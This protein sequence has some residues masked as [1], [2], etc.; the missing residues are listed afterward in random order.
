MAN[1]KESRVFGA[2]F[3]AQCTK[4]G[5]R[6][7]TNLFDTERG[8]TVAPSSTT[9][10]GALLENVLRCEVCDC[11]TVLLSPNVTD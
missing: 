11:T 10:D 5:H 7:E 6:W 8:R 4:C 2:L 3:S 9:A 1:E